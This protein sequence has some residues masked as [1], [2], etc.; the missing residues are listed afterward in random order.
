MSANKPVVES[1][2]TDSTIRSVV[3]SP[4]VAP[5]IFN[6]DDGLPSEI[7]DSYYIQAN[8]FKYLS[9]TGDLYKRP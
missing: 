3:T 9:P 1:S 5:I 8:G 4:F 6:A 2:V 7:N